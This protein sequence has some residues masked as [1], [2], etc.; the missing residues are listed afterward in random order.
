MFK[1]SEA[2]F[3][4][5]QKT[6]SFEECSEKTKRRRIEAFKESISEVGTDLFNKY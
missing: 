1:V 2:E 4:S 5:H 6:K 3:P